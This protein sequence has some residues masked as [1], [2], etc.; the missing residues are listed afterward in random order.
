MAIDI[1]RTQCSTQFIDA[2]RA[3]ARTEPDPSLVASMLQGR[4]EVTAAGLDDLVWAL[5]HDGTC[6][7]NDVLGML[8]LLEEAING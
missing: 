5:A 4:D 1:D 3:R 7:R 6:H 2:L 8:D